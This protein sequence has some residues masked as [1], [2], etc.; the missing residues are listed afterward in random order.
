MAQTENKSTDWDQLTNDNQ[1]HFTDEFPTPDIVQNQL[2]QKKVNLSSTQ[3]T[4]QIA[5]IRDGVVVLKDGSFRVVIKAA[6]INFDLMNIEE[7]E[8]IEYAYQN[9]INSLYFPLQI[10]IQSRRIDGDVYFKK[11]Q[12]NL[13]RQKNML[14]AVLTEDYLDF[15]TDLVDNADIMDKKFY[16]IIPFYHT[17]FTKEVATNA[18][19]N[20]F[21]KLWHFKKKFSPVIIDEK[22]LEQAKKELRYR[23]Q[24]VQEGLRLC[25]IQS[26][27]LNTQELIAFY[28][29]FYNHGANI[30]QNLINFQDISTPFVD[31]KKTDH[32][33]SPIPAKKRCRQSNRFSRRNRCQLK[34]QPISQHQDISWKKKQLCER[35]LSRGL[36]VYW[37]LSL[38]PA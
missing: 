23:V 20:L 19:K 2:N 37:T 12:E 22:S 35:L 8:A 21:N 4:I 34:K 31:K 6:A 9:F 3:Q 27:L 7:R 15:I 14:L 13:E 18:G 10:H 26:Q 28:Y 11:L 1:T 25:S 24:T 16:V 5:E 36:L 17:E 38:L 32:L 33:K 29:E 30:D